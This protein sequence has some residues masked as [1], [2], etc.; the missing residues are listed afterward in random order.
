MANKKP[1]PSTAAD[2]ELRLTLSEAT[3]VQAEMQFGVDVGSIHKD[4]ARVLRKVKRAIATT[5]RAA[6]KSTGPGSA[7]P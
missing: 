1:R 4:F 3:L 2:I 6:L 5:Q 7:T